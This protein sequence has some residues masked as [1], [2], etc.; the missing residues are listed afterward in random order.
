M[1]SEYMPE[2][3]KLDFKGFARKLS[4]SKVGFILLAAFCFAWSVYMFVTPVMG[5]AGLFS[6]TP[7]DGPAGLVAL[8]PWCAVALGFITSLV[9][10]AMRPAWVLGWIEPLF[11]VFMLLAGLWG[12]YSMSQLG[13]FSSVYLFAGVYL[14]LYLAAIA[15]EL[16]RRGAQRWYIELALA[17]AVWVVSMAGGLNMAADAAQ[18]GFA[19]VAFFIAAWGF[20][21]GAIKLYDGS[22]VEEAAA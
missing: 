15:L 4:A 16:F 3:K 18:V 1:S 12:I 10:L 13:S 22:A 7:T 8:L 21:Y 9:T 2:Y 11:D 5:G 14:A 6:I 20:V 19:C 17:A